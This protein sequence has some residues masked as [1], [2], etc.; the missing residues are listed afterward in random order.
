[1]TFAELVSTTGRMRREV[2]VA[3][4]AKATSCPIEC[5][6]PVGRFSAPLL[7]HVAITLPKI[8]LGMPQPWRF[9][10]YRD[11]QPEIV[12]SRH[13][14]RSIPLAINGHAAHALLFQHTE[15][16]DRLAAFGTGAWLAAHDRRQWPIFAMQMSR[17]V[18]AYHE[19]LRPEAPV[20]AISFSLSPEVTDLDKREKTRIFG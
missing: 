3:G 2:E 16:S 17:R 11:D 6:V 12:L 13:D 15:V 19:L 5:M 20:C 8:V 9:A 1:M 10:L 18:P 7:G 4:L 14:D